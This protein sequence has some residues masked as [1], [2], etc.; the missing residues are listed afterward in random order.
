MLYVIL[1]YILPG[2]LVT[3]LLP[4]FISYQGG[5][6]YLKFKWGDDWKDE[7]YPYIHA[8]A[9]FTPIFNLIWSILLTIWY[10]QEIFNKNN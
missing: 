1:L 2:L 5:T 7:Y 9:S 4:K 10:V 8:I 3:F 6:E